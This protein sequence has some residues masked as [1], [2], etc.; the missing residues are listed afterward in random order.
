MGTAAGLEGDY[1]LW[2][3][4]HPHE[5]DFPWYAETYG[6]GNNRFVCGSAGSPPMG[7]AR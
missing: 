1:P 3:G 5:A 4:V 2:C 6:Y 7:A